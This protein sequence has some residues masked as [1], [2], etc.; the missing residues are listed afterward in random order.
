MTQTHLVTMEYRTLRREIEAAKQRIF[1]L[2]GLALGALPAAYF[3][4]A[5]YEMTAI[6]LSLPLLIGAAFFVYLSESLSVMRCGRYIRLV[7]EPE[8]RRAYASSAAVGWEQ[9]LERGVHGEQNRRLVDRFSTFFF[10][11]VY[12]FYYIA[13]VS[14]AVSKADD[15]FGVLA[16]AA[17]IGFYCALGIAFAAVMLR[18]FRRVTSTDN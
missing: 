11:L 18:S 4:A 14:L 5:T 7:L 1:K 8:M 10:Y 12:G 17:V 13:A 9:W 6:I 3:L 2:A 16:C 15:E